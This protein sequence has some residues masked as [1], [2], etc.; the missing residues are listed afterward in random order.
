MG[1]VTNTGLQS[2]K[3]DKES[4]LSN[5]FTPK[6]FTLNNDQTTEE[7]NGDSLLKFKRIG[8]AMTDAIVQCV[9][10][11]KQSPLPGKE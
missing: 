5:I 2:M 8:R 7:S 6:W 11:F 3:S 9:V 4:N 1:I 10:L